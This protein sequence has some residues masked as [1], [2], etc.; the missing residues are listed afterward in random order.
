MAQVTGVVLPN[1]GDRIKTENYN[2]PINKILAQVNG[3][4]DSSNIT[5]GS[6][7]WESMANFT[8]KIP[9]AALQDAA[10]PILRGSETLR[11]FVFTGLTWSV[12][13][14]LNG[15]LA[16]GTVYI[17]GARVLVS[18]VASYAFT[19]SRDTYVD[20][21]AT[22]TVTYTPVVNNAVSPAL[23]AGSVRIAIVVT[24]GTAI[25]FINQGQSDLSLVGLAPI[26]N[27]LKVT[28]A[29]SIGN[30]IYPTDPN[31]KVVG[32]RGV[33]GGS[34]TQSF[35]GAT[36]WAQLS[37]FGSSGIAFI[38]DGKSRYKVTIYVPS[39]SSDTNGKNWKL[40]IAL[41]SVGGTVVNYA[42][43]SLNTGVSVSFQDKFI[44]TVGYIRPT[45]GMH[46]IFPTGAG[47][48]GA[49]YQYFSNQDGVQGT[50]Y[51]MIEKS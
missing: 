7:A 22:G 51:V 12:L 34:V 44:E 11:N 46:T 13:S 45:A 9:G 20:V 8:N 50:A 10:N 17:D 19:A 27:G 31:P 40:G 3:N 18:A 6:L 2:D 25:T 4:L 43:A 5:P 48:T 29:D 32:Y 36:S 49:N 1:N 39:T 33:Y 38:A 30:L 15:A 21:S 35:A 42:S 16:S 26:I 41:D 47:Q 24:S 23:A 28:I 14:G 37:L